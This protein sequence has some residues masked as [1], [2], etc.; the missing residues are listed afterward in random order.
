MTA[1][2][3]GTVAPVAMSPDV[4]VVGTD[5]TSSRSPAARNS[6]AVTPRA[7]EVVA[8]SPR[9][10]D[11]VATR[12]ASADAAAA[13]AVAPYANDAVAMILDAGKQIA[14]SPAAG[15]HVATVARPQ[16]VDVAAL[17]SPDAVA[18]NTASGGYRRARAPQRSQSRG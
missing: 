3:G 8:G 10:P 1:T 11:V 9:A 17:R 12:P 4:V 14:L 2:S 15:D 13:V 5:A 6:S 7:R 16:K 18:T